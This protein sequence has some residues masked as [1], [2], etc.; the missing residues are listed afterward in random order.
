[1]TVKI[2]RK[3]KDEGL[4]N[5][6]NKYLEQEFSLLN[7]LVEDEEYH[8]NYLVKANNYCRY[9]DIRPYLY[10]NVNINS[11]HKFINASWIHMPSPGMFIA[12]QGPLP[13]T[14]EDFWTMCDQ[15]DIQV[16]VMLCKVKENNMEKCASYWSAKNMNKY[17]IKVLKDEAIDNGIVVRQFQLLNIMK[18]NIV[19]NISQIHLTC[20]EDHTAL[21]K[22]HF[23]KVIKLIK[24]VDKYKNNKPAII[25][26]SAGVGRTG[27]FISLYNLYHVIM[28]QIF[29]INNDVIEFSVFNIVRKIKEMRMYMVENE[30]QY[31]LLYYFVNYL[32]AM[33]N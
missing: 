2:R 32:L 29:Y 22:D 12:T 28:E 25:H 21:S 31:I 7:E 14:I 3:K 15:Y 5:Y 19:K 24:F 13:N 18:K 16:I 8:N 23:E 9:K 30:N 33:Y 1:M 6:A 10:N 11:S 17:E 4:E 26:C 20:W 27:T